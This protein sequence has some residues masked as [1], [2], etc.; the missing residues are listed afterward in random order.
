NIAHVTDATFEAE[1]L[2]SPRPVLV[3]FW[4]EWCPP[5]KLLEPI[6]EAIAEERRDALTVVKLNIEEHQRTA[7]RYGVMS[8]PTMALFIGGVEKTRLIG[9]MPKRAILAELGEFLG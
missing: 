9:A 8:F 7:S 2:R 4:A 3:D 6:L 5:C 1:V